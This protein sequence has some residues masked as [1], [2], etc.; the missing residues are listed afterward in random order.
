MYVSCEKM[1]LSDLKVISPLIS[2][3]L[4]LLFTCISQV[5]DEVGDIVMALV[6]NKVDLI[7]E[8]KMT[9]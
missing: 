7:E 5:E 8:A 2:N 3:C 1:K 4:I 9:V 6:Q